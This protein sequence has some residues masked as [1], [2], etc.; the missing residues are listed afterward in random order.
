MKI[1]GDMPNSENIQ[2][3]NEEIDLLNMMLGL[4]VGQYIKATYCVD[5]NNRG[6]RFCTKWGGCEKFHQ[7]S[8][9]WRSEIKRRAEYELDLI[10]KRKEEW[11][12]ERAK[13]G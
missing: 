8:Q 6:G 10:R 5:C 9:N 7:L 12:K 3:L 2:E 13:N 11:E 1:D 4:S